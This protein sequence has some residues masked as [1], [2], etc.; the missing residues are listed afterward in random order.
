MAP[1]S[2][3]AKTCTPTSAQALSFASTSD[4]ATASRHEAAMSPRLLIGS[5]PIHAAI[6]RPTQCGEQTVPQLD[7][8]CMPFRQDPGKDGLCS[9]LQIA[10][11]SNPAHIR[12]A[13][14]R[15][16]LCRDH[17]A[18]PI[19]IRKGFVSGAVPPVLRGQI[20][21]NQLSGRV[22][23]EGGRGCASDPRAVRDERICRSGQGRRLGGGISRIA[24]GSA[25]AWDRRQDRH[26]GLR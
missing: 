23:P 7:H 15:Y 19:C 13:D 24:L 5:C 14:N 22:R 12:P 18:N 25:A 9:K 21:T 10:S 4:R 2:G 16:L 6:F 3:V 8:F 1:L 26:A 20:Q 17:A 11:G